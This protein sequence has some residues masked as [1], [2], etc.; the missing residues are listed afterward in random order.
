MF[1]GMAQTTE[2]TEFGWNYLGLFSFK[3]RRVAVSRF[4]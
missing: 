4:G 3:N 2:G 1:V